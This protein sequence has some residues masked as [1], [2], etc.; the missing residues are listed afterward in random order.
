MCARAF[1]SAL[2]VAGYFWCGVASIGNA[3]VDVEALLDHQ[4]LRD[5][6]FMNLRDSATQYTFE[7]VV[8]YLPPGVLPGVDVPVPV[9]HIRFSSTVFFAFDRSS[10]EP[11]AD[12]TLQQFARTVLQDKSLRSILVV[13]HT[14]S[15]GDEEYNNKLSLA[16]AAAVGKRLRSAGLKD[17]IIGVVPM[18][19]SKP[20]STNATE[21]GR[22]LN[23][24]VEFFISEVPGAT[25]KVIEMMPFNP[26]FRNDDKPIATGE[27]QECDTSVKRIPVLGP[28]GEGRA[29]TSI[30]LNRDAMAMRPTF[31]PPLPNEI[32]ERPSIKQLESN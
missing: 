30:D 14:D 25:T 31:R 28:S 1:G 16:R 2:L 6:L 8:L 13:G 22:A 19:K 7:Y 27:V 5:G 11:T 12:K 32:R 21:E 24:R 20:F 9:T 10:L 4:K 29:R 26:C 3:A 15:V 23:R 18:G 17:E